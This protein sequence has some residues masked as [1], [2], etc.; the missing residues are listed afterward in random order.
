MDMFSSERQLNDA[1]Q[2]QK[3]EVQGG[4]GE[5]HPENDGGSAHIAARAILRVPAVLL[6][7]LRL[8]G[9]NGFFVPG[10]FLIHR[11]RGHLSTK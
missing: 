8:E 6:H 9:E 11:Q 4:G 5:Q 7:L 3:P 2:A 10:E 1:E